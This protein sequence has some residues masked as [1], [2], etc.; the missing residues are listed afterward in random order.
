VSFTL[1]PGRNRARHRGL[2]PRQLI[3][4]I[5]SLE[6]EANNTACTIIGLATEI[7]ELKQ[8]RNDLKDSL[9]AAG[10]DYSGALE[11][12]AVAKETNVRLQAENARLRADLANATAITVPQ[13]ERDTNAI[14]DQA[15][16]PIDVRTLRQA[17][18][19]GLL[20]PVV[21]TSTSGAT[22]NPGTRQ[23]SWGRNTDDTQPLPKAVA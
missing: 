18:E 10:I 14:E 16:A 22:A 15:T 12:V 13:M 4:K 3:Q 1:I 7:D 19:D 11:D 20:S 21:R 6:C 5:S 17:A 23:T 2:T 8:Q 9:D